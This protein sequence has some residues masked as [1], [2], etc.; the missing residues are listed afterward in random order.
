MDKEEIRD[1]F[2]QYQKTLEK[3]ESLDVSV[4]TQ[5]DWDAWRTAL[6]ERADYLHHEYSEMKVQIEKNLAVFKADTPDLT[7]E[8]WTEFRMALRDFYSS[9]THDLAVV[10][11]FAELLLK[12]EENR[13]HGNQEAKIQAWLYLGY[14]NLEYSRIINEKFGEESSLYYKK[15]ADCWVHYGETDSVV[16]HQAIVVALVNLVMCCVCQGNLSPEEGYHYWQVMKELQNSPAFEKTRETR[17]DISHL[18]DVYIERYK[19]DAFAVSMTPKKPFDPALKEILMGMTEQAYAEYMNAPEWTA[20]MFQAL[21][22][23]LDCARL[24]GQKTVDECWKIIHEFYYATHDKVDPKSIDVISYYMTCLEALIEFLVDCDMPREEKQKYFRG[25]QREIQAFITDYS[26]RSSDIYTL[27]S[28]LETLAFLPNSYPLFDTPAEKIDFLYRLV[29]VRHCTTFLHSQMVCAFAEAILSAVIDE[30]PEILLGY[31]GLKDTAE[32]QAHKAELIQFIHNAALLHDM[33]KNAML[34]IIETQ[35]R[36]LSDDEFGIIRQHPSK[37]AEFLSIDPD[38]ARYK[39]ITNGH[40]KFYNG[41]GGYPADFDNTAS[42]ERIMIDMITLCD[43]LDA[44][45]DC[46][47]RNYH[48]AKTVD[49]V[50]DEFR[51]DSGVRYNP[52]LVRFLSDNEPLLQ[53]LHTLAGKQRLEIYYETYQKYFM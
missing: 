40:H 51:R 22:S 24:R 49:Q 12:H 23:S 36:P 38:L 34:T 25:Y 1:F 53:K 35:H 8:I 43:C 3:V 26:Q 13:E 16:I 50:M 44:A 37:G 15:V 27:N 32:I 45:T 52:D 11:S 41:K 7:D 28:A 39:D 21:I 20:D 42:P 18:L 5:R 17:P 47:G 10:K 48:F 6:E 2:T 33:G 4:R 19:T 30:A 46:Y 9:D 31:H 14:A 29:I